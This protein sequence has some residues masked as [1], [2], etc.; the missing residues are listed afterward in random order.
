MIK[1]TIYYEYNGEWFDG[2]GWTRDRFKAKA[3]GS[4]ELDK[5]LESILVSGRNVDIKAFNDTSVSTYKLHG[6]YNWSATLED[7]REGAG[8]VSL[9]IGHREFPYTW[10][11][12]GSNSIKDFILDTDSSYFCGKLCPYEESSVFS[13]K[14]SLRAIKRHIEQEFPYYKHMAFQKDMR[15]HLKRLETCNDSEKFMSKFHD[16]VMY[17]FDYR[18]IEDRYD[19]EEVKL[20]F[21]SFKSCAWEYLETEPSGTYKLIDEM[22]K[23]LKAK[24]KKELNQKEAA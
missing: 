24:L 15:K 1:Y 10:G 14:A 5:A 19:R 22:H 6:K 16:V 12:I 3:M 7:I 20:F 11:A 2:K 13:A 18:L 17:S 21:D 23:R 9:Y 8:R 4:D